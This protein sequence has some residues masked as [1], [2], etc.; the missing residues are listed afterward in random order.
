MRAAWIGCWKSSSTELQL[1]EARI[2]G[3]GFVIPAKAGIQKTSDRTP[4]F[5]GS[6]ASLRWCYFGPGR[7]NEKGANFRPTPARE[8]Q[9]FSTSR[10]PEMPSCL[11]GRIDHVVQGI[12]GCG[13]RGGRDSYRPRLGQHLITKS[14]RQVARHHQPHR[15]AAR[16]IF[17]RFCRRAVEGFMQLLRVKAIVSVL[18][19]WRQRRNRTLRSLAPHR[20]AGVGYASAWNAWRNQCLEW[21]QRL[22]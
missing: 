13:G 7:R 15:H 10:H 20:R 14:L 21:D 19:A 9:A 16:W 1:V 2:F 8:Q 4:A 12:S 11:A 3:T 5:A 6:D 17:R 22:P 18:K